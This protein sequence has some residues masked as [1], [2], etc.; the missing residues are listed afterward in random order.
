MAHPCRRGGG[1]I[2]E[3]RERCDW[4]EHIGF[5]VELLAVPA[6]QVL[7]HLAGLSPCV[8][9]IPNVCIDRLQ[10]HLVPQLAAVIHDDSVDLL[11]SIAMAWTEARACSARQVY[12]C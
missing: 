2:I 9:A 10:R 5:V 4:V 7:L 1:V 11:P 8:L 12:C 6:A 3:R